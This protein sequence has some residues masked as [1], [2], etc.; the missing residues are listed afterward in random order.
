MTPV[1]LQQKYNRDGG[2][3]GWMARVREVCVVSVVHQEAPRSLIYNTYLLGM[4]GTH[5]LYL[6]R[7]I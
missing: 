5:L 2:G 7:S 4:I 6:E 1:E 3:G